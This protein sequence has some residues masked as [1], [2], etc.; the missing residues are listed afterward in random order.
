MA[1]R[2]VQ[3]FL[4][5]YIDN[6]MDLV[7]T[8]EIERHL[9][10][11]VVCQTSYQNYLTIK[12]GLK[13]EQF[14]Y[15]LPADLSKRIHQSLRKAPSTKTKPTI[16]HLNLPWPKL[17]LSVSIGTLMVLLAV[18]SLVF[19]INFA[20]NDSDQLTQEVLASHIRSLMAVN[21][22]TDVASTNQH[23]V[24]P[25][26]DG[27]LNFSPV[28]EDFADKGYP[29]AGGRLDYLDKQSVAALIYL[30]GKHIINVFIWRN[31]N[32]N[33]KQDV[34]T[35]S[36]QGYHLFHWIDGGSNYWVV[37]DLNETELGTFVKLVKSASSG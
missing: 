21:H 29:L 1:C 6:E 37:S 3:K 33:L 13:A 18:S 22:L 26:F 12:K 8:L 23:T 19:L 36:L 35:T 4:D 10:D 5:G 17:I 32:P 28:V 11:C 24:K 27:K 20:T 9:Q 14:Y 30:R 31:N 16:P 2:E 7:H 25:W 34:Q 15:K